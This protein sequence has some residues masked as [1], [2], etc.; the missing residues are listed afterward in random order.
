VQ[1]RY[2][3]RA[4]LPEMLEVFARLAQQVS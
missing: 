3:L 4:L 2:S 1:Q